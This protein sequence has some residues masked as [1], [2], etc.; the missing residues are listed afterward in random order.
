MS[1]LVAFLETLLTFYW[2]TCTSK[3]HCSPLHPQSLYFVAKPELDSQKPYASY[4]HFIAKKTKKKCGLRQIW[5]ET[6]LLQSEELEAPGN[7]FKVQSF[8]CLLPGKH[9]TL[10]RT[11]VSKQETTNFKEGTHGKKDCLKKGNWMWRLNLDYTAHTRAHSAWMGYVSIQKI[12]CTEFL[13]TR[14]RTEIT[15][16]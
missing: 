2:K 15:T 1:I 6:H 12:L 13:G 14:V 11:L 10:P 5:C 4:L 16:T 3:T 7:T 9:V 8:A